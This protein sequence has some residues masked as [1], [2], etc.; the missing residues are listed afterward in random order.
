MN[1]SRSDNHWHSFMSHDLF[2]FEASPEALGEDIVESPAFSIHTDLNIPGFK[3]LQVAGTGEMASLVA[4]PDRGSGK[5]ESP[6]HAVQ[7][8]GDLQGVIQFP[9]D[10]IPRE[11]V[12]CCHQ[13]HPSV[14]KS[15][16]RDIDAPDMMGRAGDHVPEKIGIDPV[17]KVPFA[18]IG[19][20]MN[21][22][23]AHLPHGCLDAFPAHGKPFFLKGDGHLA[24]P[25]KGVLGIDL[26]N[27]VPKP[28]LFFRDPHRP[29]IQ[30]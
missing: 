6:I 13:I 19:A 29:V 27:P 11:P 24:A 10:D 18:E 28:N 22:F 23:D 30:G 4:I 2:V 9:G 26:I 5:G 20:R 15:D 3:A 1:F 16:I 25:V 17:L 12:N 14:E 21:P 8:K 7:N